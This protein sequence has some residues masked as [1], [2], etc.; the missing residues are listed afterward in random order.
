LANKF[1]MPIFWPAHDLV[2][3]ET[4]PIR[5]SKPKRMPMLLRRIGPKQKQAYGFLILPGVKVGSN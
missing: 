5:L 1:G 4:Q 2:N 3:F